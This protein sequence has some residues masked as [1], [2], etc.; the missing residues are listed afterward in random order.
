MLS[1]LEQKKEEAYFAI[2]DHLNPF[3]H[4]LIADEL[5]KELRPKSDQAKQSE[6]AS[7]K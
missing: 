7:L 6:L 1:V 5:I 4:K 3:G 2:D